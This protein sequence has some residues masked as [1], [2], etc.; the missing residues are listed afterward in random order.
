MQPVHLHGSEGREA[1]T[2]RGTVIAI[3]ELLKHH[4]VSTAAA[5]SNEK[6][7]SN[8]ALPYTPIPGFRVH[9]T[10]SS[11]MPADVF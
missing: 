8:C 10:S 5:F 7:A 9:Q 2:G 6:C 3:R 4:H 11:T 1:A